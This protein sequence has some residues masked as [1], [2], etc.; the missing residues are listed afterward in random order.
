MTRIRCAVADWFIGW[1]EGRL[2]AARRAAIGHGYATQRW[3]ERYS[4]WNP[5]GWRPR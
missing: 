5:D 2:S 1:H 3:R 4:R